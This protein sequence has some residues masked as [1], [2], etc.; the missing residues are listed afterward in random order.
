HLQP[1]QLVDCGVDEKDCFGRE[2]LTYDDAR[3]VITGYRSLAFAHRGPEKGPGLTK[4]RTTSI[5]EPAALGVLYTTEALKMPDMKKSGAKNDPALPPGSY[6]LSFKGK[7]ESKA[8]KEKRRTKKDGDK[9]E[10]DSG[11][12]STE[13][14]GSDE[15]AKSEKD[16]DTKGKAA[17]DDKKDKKDKEDES[18]SGEE[19]APGAAVPWPGVSS[20]HT[21]T[22][23]IEFPQDDD[24][25]LFIND[26]NAVVGW[27]RNSAVEEVDLKKHDE[28]SSDE[29]RTWKVDFSLDQ[30]TG[31][32]GPRFH[33]EFELA[34]PGI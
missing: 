33:L 14:P 34:G 10:P 31:K 2:E 7:G 22:E 6:L 15:P 17:K 23:D 11:D 26:N 4:L 30:M 19:V 16:K 21:A 8:H 3:K 29:K 28:E 12:Q 13:K 20:V 9:P 24:L 18:K 25:I 27:A 5:D 1:A 32:R